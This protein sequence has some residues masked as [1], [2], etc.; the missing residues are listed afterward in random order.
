MN[1]GERLNNEISA[2]FGGLVSG[3]VIVLVRS[4]REGLKYLGERNFSVCV[5]DSFDANNGH[6]CIDNYL[7]QLDRQQRVILFA[8]EEEKN[9]LLAR[10]RGY[11]FFSKSYG[12]QGLRGRM[13]YA[14][15]AALG[16]D[17]RFEVLFASK[18][19]A[20]REAAKADYRRFYGSRRPFPLSR[21]FFFE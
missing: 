2:A 14:L 6:E 20:R 4:F 3:P 17:D 10:E 12:I 18:R 19:E 13:Y 9:L 8:D 15:R 21:R 11:D 7:D 1:N 16:G 5:T